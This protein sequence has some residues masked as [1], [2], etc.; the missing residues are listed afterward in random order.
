[1]LCPHRGRTNDSQTA[2]PRGKGIAGLNEGEV[3]PAMG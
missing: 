2:R 1:M 3:L